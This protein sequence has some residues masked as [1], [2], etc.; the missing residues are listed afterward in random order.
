MILAHKLVELPSLITVTKKNT[1][2]FIME[3]VSTERSVDNT[4]LRTE[5]SLMTGTRYYC[6]TVK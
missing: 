5:S 1:N 3:T 4:T 2:Y 6:T